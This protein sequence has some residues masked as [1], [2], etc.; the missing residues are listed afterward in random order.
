MRSRQI[1]VDAGHRQHAHLRTAAA[2]HRQQ[3]LGLSRISALRT[4]TRETP[5]A[6]AIAS[7]RSHSPGAGAPR[8]M[9]SR[10]TW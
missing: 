5:M 7:W 1:L 8:M 4:G 2:V 6:S 9:L 3:A 10:S